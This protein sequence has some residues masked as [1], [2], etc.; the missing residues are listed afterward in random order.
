MFRVL[1]SDKL[2]DDAVRILEGRNIDVTF[3]PGLGKD[4][5]RLLEMIGDY[6]GLAI[7]SATTV[8]QDVIEAGKKLKV[9]G[10]A[11]IGVDNIDIPSATSAGIAVMNTPFGNSVTTAEH[12][13]A[14]MFALARQ[15]PQANESTHQGKWEK[16]RFMGLELYGK[17]LGLIG[18][19]NIGSIVADRA[20][21]LRMKAIAFD[22]YLTPERA[23]ELGV[24]KVDLDTLLKRADVITLHTPLTDGTR[25]ILSADA[26]SK[27][28]R[29]VRIV[30]CARGGLID[31][32]ALEAALESGQ[33]GGAALD[34]FATEPAKKH[35][36]FGRDDVVCT[37]HLG[38]ATTEA[39]ENVAIQIAE[40]IADYLLVG[41]VSNALNM[42]SVTA[43]EAP[44]L[45]PY[46]ALAEQL[47]TLAGQVAQVA[48]TSFE[49]SLAGRVSDLNEGPMTAAALAGAMRQQLA[50]VNL[51]NAQAV[52]EDR[53]VAI[54]QS[55]THNSPHYDA[56]ITV[57]IGTDEG[58]QTFVG[59]LFGGE[60][61]LVRVGN[62]R[63]EASFA[64]HMLLLRNEDKPGFIGALGG[65]LSD[66][67]VN[68][69]TFHLG[70]GAD[71]G[72][73]I[74]LVT[75]DESVPE[76]VMTKIRALP[77]TRSAT[78]LSF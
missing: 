18:C 56:T 63:L 40:Q 68:V 35:T 19:G 14:M 15:I 70:R 67:G 2:G 57:T 31:E 76:E 8:T 74:A 30:N 4:P 62:I 64:P 69:A 75:T 29:G 17:T 21:G 45:K 66:A 28:K 34:V 33:V 20:R 60:P 46:I 7:R 36:L 10:R 44:K 24:E 43:E 6:D 16:S 27:T 41:A 38:A 26:L 3:D 48:L 72:T 49:I 23:V 47:G 39:Q 32:D 65:V 5:A 11:G 37:P 12:A 71:D 55:K 54:T 22:P 58:S 25:N 9:V 13:I 1:I 61:R 73:A 42:A 50:G 78:A 52:A 51:V 77:Q 53:G 59:A